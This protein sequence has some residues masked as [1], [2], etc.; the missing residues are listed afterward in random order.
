MINVLYHSVQIELDHNACAN[1]IQHFF[2]EEIVCLD[3][4]SRMRMEAEIITIYHG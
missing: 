2:C 3:I 1:T 4:I